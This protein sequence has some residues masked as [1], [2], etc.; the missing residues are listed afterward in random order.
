MGDLQ[1]PC[2]PVSVHLLLAHDGQILLSLRQNTGFEDGKYSLP[3]GKL[4]QGESV[5]T[6]MLREAHEELGIQINQEHL[7]ILHVMNR[8]GS[9]ANRIDYFF[10]CSCWEGTIINQEPLKRGGLKWCDPNQL[11]TSTIPYVRHAVV[12]ILRNEPFSLYGWPERLFRGDKR[13]E[14]L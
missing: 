9:D 10:G 7:K 8:L 1:I 5:V 6:G 3:A 2:F 14:P 12:C 4:E 11:P 13:S